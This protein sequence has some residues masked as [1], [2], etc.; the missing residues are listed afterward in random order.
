[1]TTQT[2]DL[3]TWTTEELLSEVLGRS[4]GDRPAL[5]R[6]QVLTMRALL[7]DCD[8]KA[9]AGTPPARHASLPPIGQDDG[10]L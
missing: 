8:Q 2:P 9:D 1:M 10:S 6:I 4:A 5:D 7:S 3:N